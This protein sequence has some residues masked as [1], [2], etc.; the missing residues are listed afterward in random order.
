MIVEQNYQALVFRAMN[1]EVEVLIYPTTTFSK[2]GS[3]SFELKAQTAAEGVKKLFEKMEASLSR[4]RPESEL[5]RLNRQGYLEEASPLL[6][7]SLSRALEMARLTNGIF[8]PTILAALETAGYDRSFELLDRTGFTS[9]ARVNFPAFNGY[10]EVTTEPANRFIRLPFATRIDL[11]GIA[12]GMTVDMAS[13]LLLQSGFRDFMVSA[14]GDMYLN[15]SEPENREGWQVSVQNPLTLTDTLT[16]LRVQNQG[17]ATSA[18]T[19]RSW[20]KDGKSQNH[21]IDPRTAQPVDNGLASVTVIAPTTTLADV[22]AKTA[23]ILGPVEGPA[24]IDQQ[25]GC[26]ALFCGLDG[27]LIRTTG[28][29]QEN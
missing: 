21:L 11:G 29:L 2:S 15:G 25:P 10:L 17:I 18:I 24:F 19:K 3:G 5:C 1:T 13:D 20:L 23:L 14:G 9:Q 26:S 16:L 8:D 27:S 12:K 4:F 28:L 6:Y 7:K 22:L